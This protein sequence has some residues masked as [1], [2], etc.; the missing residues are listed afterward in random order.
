MPSVILNAELLSSVMRDG[1]GGRHMAHTLRGTAEAYSEN[2][3]PVT[4]QVT[5]P[6]RGHKQEVPRKPNLG[7][8]ILK[9]I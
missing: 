1:L 9:S 5:A 8:G 7:K 6:A 3:F 2:T 4:R